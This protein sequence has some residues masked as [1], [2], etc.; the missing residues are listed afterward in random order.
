M[1][2]N[3]DALLA[4]IAFISI[5][6]IWSVMKLGGEILEKQKATI[7]QQADSE[8]GLRDMFMDVD[9]QK[10]FMYN[11][12]ALIVAPA[13][14]WV[15]SGNLVL[16]VLTVLGIFLLPRFSVKF[17]RKRRFDQFE[18]QLPDALLMVSGAMRA[19]ASLTVA[20]EGMVKEQRPPLSQEF[21]LMLREQRLG[22][23][24]DSALK[25]MEKRLPIPDFVMV[26]AGM[27]ISREVGGNLADILET[28]ADTLRRKHT[29]EGKIK[30][31]T[32]QGKM[33]GIIMTALPLF[34]MLILTY[35]EPEAM[36]PL[37]HTMMGW[38]VLAIVAVMEVIGY[39][40]INKI[41]TID[42]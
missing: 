9:P 10:L 1:M 23:D 7:S 16:V 31:L 34:L 37:Y 6:V 35:M 17:L 27:R 2:Q 36:Q 28:L 30:A 18:K 25:N 42:V 3:L 8:G 33:Q 13:I 26:V 41:T 14:V 12:T 11:L 39:V 5:I 19:G 21:G 32:A 15:L 38:A 20:M 22:L 29:M 24:F 4:V 40:A